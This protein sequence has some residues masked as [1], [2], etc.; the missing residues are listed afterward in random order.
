MSKKTVA[1]KNENNLHILNNVKLEICDNGYECDFCEINMPVVENQ[2]DSTDSILFLCRSCYNGNKE[3][4]RINENNQFIYE[5]GDTFSDYPEDELVQKLK[6][7]V[8]DEIHSL[9]V[10]S[11]DVTM[12]VLRDF[13][14][15]EE[16]NPNMQEPSG[17]YYLEI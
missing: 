2:V 11:P 12:E 14:R 17:A 16:F 6:D 7:S 15:N 13:L 1:E 8:D 5:D 3:E 4:G 10:K 9:L